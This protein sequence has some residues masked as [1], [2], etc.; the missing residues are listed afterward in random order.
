MFESIVSAMAAMAHGMGLI[1]I[2]EG[3]ETEEQF[4]IARRGGADLC[5]GFL[6]GRP[7]TGSCVLAL[8]EDCKAA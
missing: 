6:L 4:E 5:Q 7:I 8:V 3:I 1:V 2:A